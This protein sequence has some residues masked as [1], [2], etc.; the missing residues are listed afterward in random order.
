MACSALSFT[1]VTPGVMSCCVKAASARGASIPDPPPASGEAVVGSFTFTWTYDTGAQ[2]AT[3]QCIKKPFY[4]PCA[5]L[6]S[7]LRSTVKG[8]GGTPS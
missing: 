5:I 4:V 6:N 7:A 2:T 1:G 8:C 3:V